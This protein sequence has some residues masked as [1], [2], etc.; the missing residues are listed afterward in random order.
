MSWF[1]LGYWYTFYLGTLCVT[2]ELNNPGV[3]DYE[4]GVL[5]RYV[6]KVYYNLILNCIIKLLILWL[7]SE[8]PISNIFYYL[9]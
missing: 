1:T 8:K 2:G 6:G 3:D 7:K 4:R 5:D 9:R